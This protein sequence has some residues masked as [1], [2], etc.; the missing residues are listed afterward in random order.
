MHIC[1]LCKTTIE[2]PTHFDKENI[3]YFKCPVCGIIQEDCSFYPSEGEEKNRYDQHNNT[4]EDP[5]YVAYLSDIGKRTITPFVSA[6]KP[7][8]DF[9]CGPEPVLANLL[10]Q[11]GYKTYYYDLFYFPDTDYCNN[12]YGGIAAIEVLEHIYNLNTTFNT[13]L[14]LLE[15]GGFLIFRTEL[16]TGSKTDFPKWWYQRDP[17]HISLFTPDTIHYIKEIF[18]LTKRAW[19]NNREFVLQA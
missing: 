9:G 7:V 13:L 12:M 4:S 3:P 6:G 10:K 18:S 5:R 11:A 14:S 1:G 15:P 2:R 8:L 17:T 19:I 16:F